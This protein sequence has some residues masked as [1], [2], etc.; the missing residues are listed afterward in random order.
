VTHDPVS[1]SY[2]D[3]AM[4]LADGRIV[5]IMAAPTAERVLDRMK[6]LGDVAGTVPVTGGR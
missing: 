6:R 2:A 5:D 3:T 4:F 1:A